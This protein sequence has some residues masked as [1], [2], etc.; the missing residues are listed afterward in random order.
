MA[1]NTHIPWCEHCGAEIL[2]SGYL[3]DQ[4]IF[5]CKACAEGQPCDCAEH[6]FFEEERRAKHAEPA[7]TTYGE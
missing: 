5:C 7:Y 2:H 3:I 1:E 6:I 4:K